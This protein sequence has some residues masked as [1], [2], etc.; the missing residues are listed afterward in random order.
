MALKS[1]VSVLAG[2][3]LTVGVAGC[4]SS[5]DNGGESAPPSASS[6]R[7]G[8]TPAAEESSDAAAAE[9]VV[10]T[11]KD[12]KFTGPASVAPGTT[13]TVVN[14]DRSSHTLTSDKDDFDE[15]LL[16]GGAEGTFTAPTKPGN[17]AYV[18]T[19]HP[20]MTGTLVVK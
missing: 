13:V 7:S 18:C 4:S 5:D 11:I 8:G 2:V 17:Y 16:Q 3:L 20:E 10:I 1:Y 14:E 6:S 12:F 19:Y 9:P 15:V